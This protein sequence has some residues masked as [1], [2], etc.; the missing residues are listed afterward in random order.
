MPSHAQHLVTINRLTVCNRLRMRR[1]KDYGLRP[2]LV[3]PRGARESHGKRYFLYSLSR[4]AQDV[5][6]PADKGLWAAPV[7]QLGLGCCVVN[8][9]GRCFGFNVITAMEF[10]V[11]GGSGQSF[12]RAQLT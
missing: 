3:R 6:A 7:R 1:I 4:R 10:P 2:I 11:S 12:Q 8:T 5:Q 9:Q